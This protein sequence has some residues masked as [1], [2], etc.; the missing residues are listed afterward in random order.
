MSPTLKLMPMNVTSN[1]VMWLPE[2]WTQQIIINGDI[3]LNEKKV[4]LKIWITDTITK[5]S[6]SQNDFQSLLSK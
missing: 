2:I 1:N 6:L 5:W 4:S 3:C